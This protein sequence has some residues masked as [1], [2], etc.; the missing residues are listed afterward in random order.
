[1]LESPKPLKLPRWIVLVLWPV[2]LLLAHVI[3]PASLSALTPRLGWKHERPTAWNLLGFVLVVPGLIWLGWCVY[4]HFTY[5]PQ[6][7]QTPEPAP[8]YLLTSGP[9]KWSRNPMYI[10]GM[11]MWAGWTIFYGSLAVLLGA[12]AFWSG[13]IF[14]A[15]PYEERHLAARFGPSHARYKRAI[16]RWLGRPHFEHL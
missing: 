7:I 1:M 14:L 12:L 3:T 5:S 11:A 6:T 13:V 10:A 4:L 16:P 8:S 15:V 9:Y 2:M